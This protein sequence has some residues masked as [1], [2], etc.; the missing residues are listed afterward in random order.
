VTAGRALLVAAAALGLAAC[1][2]GSDAASPVRSSI[3]TPSSTTPPPTSRPTTSTTTPAR[4]QAEPPDGRGGRDESCV[5]AVEPGGSLSAI[6]AAHRGVTVDGLLV[7]NRIGVEVVLHPGDELDVCIGNDVDDVTGVSLRPP[8]AQEVRRQQRRL[9]E[10]FAPH[11]IADLVVDGDSGPLTRQLLCAARMGLGL[12]VSATDMPAGSPEEQALF[13]ADSLSVPAGAATWASRWILIDKTC[14]VIFTGE[15]GELVDVYPTSTGE[16]GHETRDVGA[17]AAFRYDPALENDGWH[18]SS[19]YPV[20]IDDPLN[21]NMYK[22]L[23]FNGGQAIHGANYVPPWPRSKGCARMFTW[24]HD[25]LLS[26]LGLD[27]I[28]Q[29]TWRRDQIGVMVT[30]QGDYRPED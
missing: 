10:L 28:T 12:R 27:G 30:V 26:W 14:Q 18:D 8:T 29:P 6:A 17:V 11:M 7:E 2:A 25:A 1:D 5:A 13:E 19:H 20:P 3:D 22:P 24:H 21:G 23:Y 16:E 4:R 9:N 15:S